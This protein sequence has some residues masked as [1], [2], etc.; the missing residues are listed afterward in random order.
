MY[1]FYGLSLTTLTFAFKRLDISVA[2]ALWSGAGIVLI[3]CAGI[4]W[5]HEPA[6]VARLLFITLI[7]VGMLGLQLASPPA[8]QRP[9]H[10]TSTTPPE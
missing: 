9:G 3:A 5:F 7:V 10:Q 2:Y 4:V 1:L 8:I 6:T